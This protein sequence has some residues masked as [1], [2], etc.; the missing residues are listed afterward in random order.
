[1]QMSEFEEQVWLYMVNHKTPV[2]VKKMARYCICSESRVRKVL[3][4][5]VEGQIADVVKFGKLKYYK[6]KD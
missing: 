2:T 6:V 4:K 1:M 5:F 3:D